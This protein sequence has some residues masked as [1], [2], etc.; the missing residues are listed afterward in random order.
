MFGYIRTHRPELKLRQ[1]EYY[2]A[3]YCG[4]CRTMGKCTGQCS[5]MTLSYDFTFLALIRM[6]LSGERPSFKKCRC[7]VH[8]IKK[9]SMAEP[10]H[11]LEYCA[12]A[13]AILGYGK[14]VDDINDEK[15]L[16]KLR[17]RILKPSLSRFRKK[18]LKADLSALD[19][20][21]TEC[22]FE[23][24]EIEKARP[25]SIDVP[26]DAFGRLISALLSFGFDGKEKSIAEV[27]GMHIGRWIYIL[28]AS[29]DFDEDKKKGRYNPLLCLYHGSEF[30]EERREMIRVALLNELCEAEK[31]LDLLDVSD[32]PDISGIIENIMYLGLPATADDVLF[33]DKCRG[34]KKT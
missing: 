20:R 9:R 5:R 1:D 21:I 4:L 24:G 22:L 19:E 10:S 3:L 23:L 14:L 6:S 25:E 34:R 29:D 13:S 12:Y 32:S 30:T 26:A 33:P 27:L 15:G 17:A 7:M 18:A 28:D 8:P 2:R 16:K 31:A 11:E